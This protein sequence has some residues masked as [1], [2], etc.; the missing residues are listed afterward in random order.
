MDMFS[1]DYRQPADMDSLPLLD[2]A[3]LRRRVIRAVD[4]GWR[5]LAFFG[6]PETA[7]PGAPGTVLRSGA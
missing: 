6:L 1:F 5:M 2:A 4:G 7:R 3:E